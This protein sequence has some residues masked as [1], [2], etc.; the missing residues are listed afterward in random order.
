[1]GAQVTIGSGQEIYPSQ[2]FVDVRER[3]SKTLFRVQVN[4]D[5][6]AGMHSQKIGN[7]LRTIDIWYPGAVEDR[8]LAVDPF[9]V[10][11]RR[12]KTVRLPNLD[13]SDFYSYLK[14]IPNLTKKL[15]KAK[16][17][18]AI[19]KEAHYV[20]AVLIRGGVFSG[21]SEKK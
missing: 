7:A 3:K 17:V 10:D 8:P 14:N 5:E 21:E 4:G 1:M 16:D 13:K 19:P 2:E 12:G 11:K 6:V 15:E 20:M 18:A 9:T